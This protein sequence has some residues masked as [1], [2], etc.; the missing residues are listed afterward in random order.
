[1]FNFRL[2]DTPDG[3]QI[4]DETLKTPYDSI[5]AVEM[6]EYMEVD[7]RLEYMERMERKQA[8]EAERKRKLTYRFIHKVACMCGLVL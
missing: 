7:A 3:N 6:L 2:I 8:R 4:I 5:T 1:M